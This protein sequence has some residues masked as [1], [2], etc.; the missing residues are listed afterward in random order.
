M[1]AK[2]PEPIAAY[3]EA[4][5]SQ[6]IEAVAA[7]FGDDSVVRDEGRERRGIDAIREWAEEVSQKYQPTTQVIDSVEDTGRTVVTARVSGGFPG[8]PVDLRYAFTLDG[9]KIARLEISP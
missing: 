5:N 8:S 3:L 9:P 1:A 7:C 6:D 2:L 4:A